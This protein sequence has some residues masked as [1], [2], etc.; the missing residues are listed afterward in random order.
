M[1]K[2]LLDAALFLG[3]PSYILNHSGLEPEGEITIYFENQSKR[4]E[5]FI[6]GRGG[7]TRT[8]Y[9]TC[10]ESFMSPRWCWSF[11]ARIHSTWEKQLHSSFLHHLSILNLS[12]GATSFLFVKIILPE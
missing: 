12:Y 3:V 8:L 7:D 9:Q 2:L 5:A 11:P 4:F 10:N 6:F 1:A